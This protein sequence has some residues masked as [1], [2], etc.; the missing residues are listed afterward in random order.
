MVD[1]FP[2]CA[3]TGDHIAYL[4]ISTDSS[5]LTEKAMSEI[6]ESHTR[7]CN[8]IIACLEQI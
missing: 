8:S 3:V 2:I 6:N 4:F 1:V 5:L 7:D